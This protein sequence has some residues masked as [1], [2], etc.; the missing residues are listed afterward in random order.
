MLG[1]IRTIKDI[2][3]LYKTYKELS[4]D[5]KTN[6]DISRLGDREAASGEGAAAERGAAAEAAAGGAAAGGA[7]AAERGGA[8]AGAAA[9][10][11]TIIHNIKT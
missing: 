3:R 9:V 5:I 10:D 4:C 11:I 1:Y 6:Q 8:A 7:V 2:L